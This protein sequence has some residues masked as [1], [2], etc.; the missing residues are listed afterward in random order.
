MYILEKQQITIMT[1][2]GKSWLEFNTI[3]EMEMFSDMLPDEKNT[4]NEF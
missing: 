1:V 4:E 2:D 3:L